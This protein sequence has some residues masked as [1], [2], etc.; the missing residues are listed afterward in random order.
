M[1][2]IK[3][4]L[5]AIA[6]A[7]LMT[8][9]LRAATVFPIATNP[10]VV[11]FSGGTAFDGTNY[12]VILVTGAGGASLAGQFF[13][14][15]GA[16][17]GTQ[18]AIGSNPGFPPAASLAFGKTNYLVA[19]SDS[20]VGSGVDMYGQ[21]ISRSGLKVGSKFNLLSA[22]GLHG[23]QVVKALAFDG[24]NFLAV[25]QDNN[26]KSFYGQLVTQAGTLSG[27][28]FLI[29]SQQQNGS[30][31]AVTWGRTNYLVVW[32]SN[33]GGVGNVN[34]AFGEL[35]SRNGSAGSPFQISQTSSVDQN[36]LAVAFDGTNYFAV[37]PWDPGPETGL[38]VTNW[39]LHG[40]FVSQTGAFPGNEF[41]AVADPGS[42][43]FPSL[44]FDGS[45]YLLAW[46]ELNYNGDLS[47]NPTNSNIYFQFYNPSGAAV[48]AEFTVF[49]P[50]GTNT[51]FLARNGLLFDGSRYAFAGSLG[52]IASSGGNITG[53]PSGEVFGA[54]I[55]V[56]A[57][58][59]FSILH[60][61]STSDGANPYFGLALAGNTLYDVAADGGSFN[62]GTV[63]KLNNA[64]M[65]F[66]NIYDFTAPVGTSGI[67]QAGTNS[68]G[69]NPYSGVI[70]SGNILYGTA[71]IGGTGGGGTMFAIYTNGTGFTNLHNFSTVAT[72][73]LGFYTNSDGAAP[74]GLI[75]AGNTLY[76]TT[77]AG[78]TNGNGTVF[79][80]NTNGTGF[81]VLHTFRP[82]PAPNSGTNSDGANPFAGM[83]L[84]G[85][86][87]YGTAIFG[88]TNGYGTVFRINTNGTG[89]TNLY[90]FT[91]GADGAL[92]YAGLIV[93]SNTLYGTTVR[94]GSGSYGTVF[95]IGTNGTG[96][97]VVHAFTGGDDGANP[98]AG[99]VL[100]GNT[101]YGTTVNG[102]LSANTGTA[103]AVNT[104]GTGFTV[105]HGFTGRG[106]GANPYGGLILSNN[107]LYGA[108][109]SAGSGGNGTLFSIWVGPTLRFSASPMAGLS[110]LT[111]QFNATNI[112]S[113]GNAITQ[114]NWNFGDGLTS[115]LQNPSHVY[116]GPGM[117]SPSLVATNNVGG[118]VL[119]AGPSITAGNFIANGG[120]ET[121]DFSDWNLVDASGDTFVDDGSGSGISPNSGSY[122]AALG[123]VG[124]LGYLSQTLTTIPGQ[125][126]LLSL[127][128]NC[129]DGV[130]P[131]EFL[132][133]WNGSAI[134]DQVDL[135]ATGWT[136]LEFVVAAT[137]TGT[138][139]QFGF[140]DDDSYLGLDGVSLLP[141]AV[142]PQLTIVHSGTNVVL[143]WPTNASSY[144]LQ[145]TT[146]LAPPTAWVTNTP[147][148]V[149]VNG[150]NT[151]TNPVSGTR[152]F[153]RLSQ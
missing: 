145:S 15:N 10:A 117:F 75:Q 148:P 120:F 46:G 116:S 77:Y 39:D 78:G 63:F 28:E 11:E 41:N 111:V 57:I 26:N 47:F 9:Q 56:S 74:N 48:G 81:T 21:F 4:S 34:Q 22:Q 27:S 146:N 109:E 90:C 53:F 125:S 66:T 114:W 107:F 95:S 44:A 110:P 130:T 153:Y 86:M 100:S 127:W 12:F 37:W 99:L 119:G 16:L 97:T 113:Q 20:S 149:V 140:R 136:N 106:D 139:L 14:T 60:G 94:G 150:Q 67:F 115:P 36:P 72:N 123:P 91:G 33:N 129:P 98:Y 51:P 19:W 141:L 13:S 142:A 144:T 79:A 38:N 45:N 29:S 118:A 122:V 105:L 58:P 54:F 55:A 152:K 24:T 43:I 112:D 147:P 108:T 32:Q 6:F 1:N 25:W 7:A 137:G 23:F 76:G 87:L 18:I 59:P 135:P 133:S 128:L 8:P 88:G 3:S 42:E 61:L 84:S 5:V 17:I 103:F 89:F 68:D 92:P 80:V 124:A 104:N 134:Y 85:S 121:G 71:N 102:G 138:V 143:T 151:V 64:G 96:F 31:A 93:S 126:Y 49:A 69:A 131:N 62:S 50:Q 2:Q 82:L 40:R 70:V 101:L 132:V 65:G 52:T 35:V 30:D 73:L 83:V